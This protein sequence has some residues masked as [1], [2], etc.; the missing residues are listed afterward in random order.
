MT[1][2][3]TIAAFVA[4]LGGTSLVA[5]TSRRLRP[6]GELPTLENWALA[7]RQFGAVLTWFLLGGTIYTAYTFAAVPGLVYGVGALGFFALPYTII[8]YPLA[9]LLLPRLWSV[10][11][12]HGY[13]T[14]GDFGAGRRRTL[15]AGPGR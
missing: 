10:A 13:L 12:R 5:V 4:V 15:P 7:D 6:R 11:R 9:F 1:D 2:G 14:V 3:A 8:V